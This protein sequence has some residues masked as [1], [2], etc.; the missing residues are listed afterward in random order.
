MKKLE[1][2]DGMELA[3]DDENRFMYARRGDS[4]VNVFQ[5]DC[6]HFRNIYKRSPRESGEDIQIMR[7]ICRAVLDS[8]WSQESSTVESTYR[9]I[10]RTIGH[11]KELGLPIT[12]EGRVPFP[13]RGPFPVSDEVGMTEAILTLRRSL[14]GGRYQDHIQFDT[15]R[16][17]RVGFSSYWHASRE[18]SNTAVV[19]NDAVKLRATTAVVYGQWFERFMKIGKH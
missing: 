5:C 3:E 19:S 9:E 10:S 7:Y 1:E 8:F 4:Y 17:I 6:C 12:G 14:D 13:K 15:T 16:R 2:E 18:V 11:A